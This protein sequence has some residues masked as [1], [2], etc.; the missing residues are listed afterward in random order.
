LLRQEYHHAHNILQYANAHYDSFIATS[1]WLN[2]QDTFNEILFR[3]FQEFL[4]NKKAP[5][6]TTL[7]DKNGV[8]IK[9]GVLLNNSKFKSTYPALQNGL[10]KIHRRRNQLPSSH[11]YDERTGEKATPLKKNEQSDL[12]LYLEDALN[13]IISIVEKLGI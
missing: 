2:F 12:K 13:E 9:Y 6:T 11:A 7:I 8:R 10:S 3:A 1:T 5:G 4:I